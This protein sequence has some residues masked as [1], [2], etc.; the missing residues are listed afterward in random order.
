[1]AKAWYT[2]DTGLM[3]R[4]TF[5]PQGRRLSIWLKDNLPP[6]GTKDL[7]LTESQQ[8]QVQVVVREEKRDVAQVELKVSHPLLPSAS[9]QQQWIREDDSWCFRPFPEQKSKARPRPET[10]R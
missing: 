8:I 7:K 5:G 3:R 1:M 6:P 9:I 2:G 4:M 10:R